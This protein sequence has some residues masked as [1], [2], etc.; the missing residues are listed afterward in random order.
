MLF[1]RHAKF[2]YNAWNH[3]KTLAAISQ[4]AG[5]DL[6]PVM[7][8]EISHL[9]ILGSNSDKHPVGWHR[10][11]YPY[12]CALVLCD[13]TDITQGHTLLRTGSGGILA[14]DCPKMVSFLDILSFIR[15]LIQKGVCLC[16]PRSLYRTCCP[17]IQRMFRANYRYHLIS[18]SKPISPRPDSASQ[19]AY[20]LRLITA[21]LAVF[22][23]QNGNR[24]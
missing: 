5:T 19:C 20:S 15:K 22:P 12:A 14:C 8:I 10:D 17:S 24:H 7:D 23:I 4:V 11:D 18:T 1:T 21:S 9:E 6:V 2:T 3:P 13:T 16:P